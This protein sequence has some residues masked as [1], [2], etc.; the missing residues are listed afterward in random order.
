VST[1]KKHESPDQTLINKV[2]TVFRQITGY[3]NGIYFKQLANQLQ[4]SFNC[5]WTKLTGM[6][7]EQWF[8]INSS[9]FAFGEGGKVFILGSM[10]EV[11]DFGPTDNV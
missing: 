10:E 7:L 5:K 2:K 9:D 3:E 4:Q 8:Q 1:D 11:S 6:K